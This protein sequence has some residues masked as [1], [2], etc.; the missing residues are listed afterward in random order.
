MAEETSLNIF[1]TYDEVI[2]IIS[3]LLTFLSLFF[4]ILPVSDTVGDYGVMLT[5]IF[6]LPSVYLASNTRWLAVLIAIT[7]I[8]STTYHAVKLANVDKEVLLN[9][10]LVDEASQVILIWLS[11]LLFVY[12][13]FPYLGIP[14]LTFIGIVVAAFGHYKLF[15]TSFDNVVAGLAMIVLLLFIFYKLFISKC[16]FN[17]NFFTYKRVWEFIIIGFGYFILASIF[18]TMA[19]EYAKYEGEKNNY[20]FLHSGWHICAYTALFFVFRSRVKPLDTILKTVRIQ[21]TEFAVRQDL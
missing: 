13:D 10:Q 8:S 4:M 7:C 17:S 14:F 16:K 6:I 15:S 19:T 21:R 12:N 20:N 11:T 1:H 18:Y 9:F 2:I 5:H 3:L